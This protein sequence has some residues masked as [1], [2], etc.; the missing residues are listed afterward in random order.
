MSNAF[1]DEAFK[2]FALYPEKSNEDLIDE[3][4]LYRDLS[5]QDIW[6]EMENL[7]NRDYDVP[8]GTAT[9]ATDLRKLKVAIMHKLRMIWDCAIHRHFGHMHDK[10]H[11]KN[12]KKCSFH[13]RRDHS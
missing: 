12:F 9:V 4:K 13:D 7:E 8:D 11:F 5:L 6:V 10:D 1:I 2:I 3:N